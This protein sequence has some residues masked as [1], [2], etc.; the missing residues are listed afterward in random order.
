MD[1][2]NYHKKAQNL[3]KQIQDIRK[4]K[5]SLD[6]NIKKCEGELQAIFEQ[7]KVDRLEVDMGLLVRRKTEN[8]YEWVIEI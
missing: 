4:Q 6:R 8:G 1:E 5:R 7:A 3:A 2:M